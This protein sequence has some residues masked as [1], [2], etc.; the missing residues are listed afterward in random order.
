MTTKSV[1]YF[2]AELIALIDR[3]FDG[4]Q[5][6][7]IGAVGIDQSM[8]SRHCAGLLI[9]GSSTIDRLAKTLSVTQALPLV[10]GYLQDHCPLHLR[11]QVEIRAKPQSGK[12]QVKENLKIDLAKFPMH[13]RTV[14]QGFIN[15]VT[16]D[17]RAAELGNILIKYYDKNKIS[18]SLT[19]TKF[20]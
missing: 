17:S 9:P 16:T 2:S 18:S 20:G 15:I 5:L 3:D 1:S 19:D 8:V 4:S 14:I 6:K 13:Q 12:V 11:P 10:V 7:F